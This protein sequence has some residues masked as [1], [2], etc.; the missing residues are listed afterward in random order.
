MTMKQIKLGI[1]TNVTDLKRLVQES[2]SY[3]D[4]CRHYRLPNNGKQHFYFRCLLDE[5]NISTDKWNWHKK[6]VKHNFVTK[7][8][9]ICKS[10]F[11]TQSGDRDEKTVC[12]RKCSNTYF[13]NKRH[14]DKIEAARSNSIRK[15]L[16]SI[17]KSPIEN[18]T[19]AVC[20]TMV[21]PKRKTQKCC[22]NKCATKL[23]SKDPSY[24]QKL[25][26]GAAR[27]IA[28]GRHKGWNK[29]RI[30]QT[31]SYAE[32]FFMGVLRDYDISYEYDKQVGKYHIDFVI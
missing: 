3:A 1:E 21:S 16:T 24:I 15:Y 23:R 18:I 17:G 6:L 7:E 19:C 12:S 26:D 20:G 29:H 10:K 31:P 11:E 28:E 27:S 25:K 22:S 2:N 4:L 30:G 32:K 5:N 14:T 9:P 13:S 8:C